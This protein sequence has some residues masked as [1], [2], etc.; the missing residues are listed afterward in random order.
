MTNKPKVILVTGTS[1]GIGKASADK[2]TQQGHIVYGC[3][4]YQ[5]G[6]TDRHLQLD[7]TDYEAC[8]AAINRIVS[9]EG[10]IDAIVNNVGYHLMGASEETSIEEIRDQFEVNFFGSLN[11]IKAATSHLV[12]QRSG[13]IINITSLPARVALPFMSA[14][15]ASKY[16]LEGYSRSLR[17]ELLP[18]GVYVANVVPGAVD[19]G[20]TDYSVK[21]T[22]TPSGIF[23]P[24]RRDITEVVRTGQHE[25][26]T[27]VT[28]LVDTI[29]N[30]MSNP[31]PA[32]TNLL[33]K[34]ANEFIYADKYLPEESVE[35]MIRSFIGLPETI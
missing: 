9:V 23:E 28:E 21:V 27:S 33:G 25:D 12:N 14:Y 22:A 19:V 29:A 8:L 5:E 3:S 2:L 11:V 35:A 7:V 24:L 34:A 18:F 26:V 15:C 13:H 1:R 32:F 30:I 17:A 4:R 16:A 31:T 20:T 10:R 6:L